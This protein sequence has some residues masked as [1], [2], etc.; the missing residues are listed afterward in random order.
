M[1]NFIE[2]TKC[3]IFGHVWI[4]TATHKNGLYLT[5][6]YQCKYCGKERKEKVERA[7]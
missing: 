1:A 5:N 3:K 6:F 4:L 7:F 2:K